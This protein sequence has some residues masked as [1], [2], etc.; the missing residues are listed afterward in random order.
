MGVAQTHVSAWNPTKLVIKKIEFERF[1]QLGLP[2]I[3]GKI[4]PRPNVCIYP[5]LM[6]YKI[7][8][9]HILEPTMFG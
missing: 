3:M 5:M 7:M 4:N 9:Y 1:V 8:R 6:A 2:K